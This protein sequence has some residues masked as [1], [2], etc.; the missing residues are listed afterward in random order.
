MDQLLNQKTLRIKL[1]K[2][3]K[4][5]GYT[6]VNTYAFDASTVEAVVKAVMGD[7]GFEGKSSVKL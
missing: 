2:Y 1:R 4:K 7:I 5:S 6:Y 3:Y